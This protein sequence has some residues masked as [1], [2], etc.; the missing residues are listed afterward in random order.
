MGRRYIIATILLALCAAA[1]TTSFTSCLPICCHESSNSS[2]A[3]GMC[4]SVSMVDGTEAKEADVCT[5]GFYSSSPSQ[6]D[7]AFSEP[8]CAGGERPGEMALSAPRMLRGRKITKNLM[9]V[10]CC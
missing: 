5:K 2:S 3:S 1:E 6:T 8:S 4:A 7:Y 10:S 9:E